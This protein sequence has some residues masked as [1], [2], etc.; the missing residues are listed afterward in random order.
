MD[1]GNCGYSVVALPALC[2]SNRGIFVDMGN[3]GYSVVA[4]PTL[5]VS[6]RGNLWI[7]VTMDTP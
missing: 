7:Q 5:C 2:V 6:N 1:M 3:Y 4:L